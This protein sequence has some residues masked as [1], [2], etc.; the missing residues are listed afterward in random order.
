MAEGQA[1]YVVTGVPGG[2]GAVVAARLLARGESVVAT[3]RDPE[4]LAAF[5]AACPGVVTVAADLAKEADWAA[6]TSTVTAHFGAVKG[7]VHAAGFDV[8]APL[9]MTSAADAQR[10]FA[11]HVGFALAFM[12]WMGRRRNHVPGASCVFVSSVAVHEGAKGH[13]AYAAA[14]GAVEGMLK[15]AAA[16][17]AGCGIRVN[18]VV[19][20]IVATAMSKAWLGR[21]TEAQRAALAATYPFG[22]GEPDAVADVIDFFLSPASRWITGQTLVCDG[23]H[24][25]A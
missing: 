24:S 18:A 12:G 4:K 8:M 9:G 15:P 2:I 14:K 3:G 19:P 25:V 16:E 6:V 1:C 21:L 20:G 10:L 13:V 22:F 11:V 23:G 5:A 7:F 17:L